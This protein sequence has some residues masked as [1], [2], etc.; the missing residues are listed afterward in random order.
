MKLELRTVIFFYAEPVHPDAGD[1][2]KLAG[3]DHLQQSGSFLEFVLLISVI[4]LH[5]FITSLYVSFRQTCG[6]QLND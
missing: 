2:G 1:A 3:A 4:Y 5:Y 6:I